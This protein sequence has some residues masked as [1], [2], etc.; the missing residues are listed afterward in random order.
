MAVAVASW[1]ALLPFLPDPITIG[2]AFSGPSTS[3]GR[4][5]TLLVAMCGFMV[6][7]HIVIVLMDLFLF[8]P[9]VPGYIMAC[10][11]W[12]AQGTAAIIYLSILGDALGFFPYQAGLVLGAAAMCGVLGVL[13][14]KSRESADQAA[15]PLFSSPYFERVSPTFLSRVLFFMRALFPRYIVIVPGGIRLIGILYDAT[16]GWDRIESVRE[17][18]LLSLFSNRPIKLNQSFSNT[19]EIHLKGRRAYPLISVGQRARFLEIAARF[20]AAG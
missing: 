10:V 8:A 3:P 19:V 9:V 5:I 20:T 17:G 12:I 1:L 18:R 6:I 13:Y 7:A 11:D 16:Y 15:A 14:R 2:S 4:P